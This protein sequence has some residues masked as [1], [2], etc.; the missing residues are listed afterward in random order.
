MRDRITT[1]AATVY[2]VALVNPGQVQSAITPADLAFSACEER[3]AARARDSRAGPI[4]VLE[5]F[6]DNQPAAW[7]GRTPDVPTPPPWNSASPPT[8]AAL[9][10][11]GKRMLNRPD[12]PGRPRTAI[13]CALAELEKVARR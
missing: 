6:Y 3:L 13:A 7:F 5:S 10:A 11:L 1:R 4:A 8:R 12:L 9:Q 2:M